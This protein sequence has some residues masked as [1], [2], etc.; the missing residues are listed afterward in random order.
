[1]EK[2]K[3][4]CLENFYMMQEN[5]RLRKKA[6]KLREENEALLAEIKQ[7]EQQKNQQLATSSGSNSNATTSTSTVAAAPIP[8]SNS[9]APCFTDLSLALPNPKNGAASS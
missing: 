8:N 4:L 6:R 1:M 5:E 2:A 7:R 9:T 3:K